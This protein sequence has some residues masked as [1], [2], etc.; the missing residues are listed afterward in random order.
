MDVFPFSDDNVFVGSL[1]SL[2]V[3]TVGADTSLW[4]AGRLMLEYGIHHVPV[5][6]DGEVIGVIT[7]TDLQYI[8]R[9]AVPS[10]RDTTD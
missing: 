2:P 7:T 4:D 8:S 1:T 6:N 5:L 10:P 3:H 9:R